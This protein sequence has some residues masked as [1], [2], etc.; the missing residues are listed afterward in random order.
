MIY[1][2]FDNRPFANKNQQYAG[3]F[4]ILFFTPFVIAAVYAHFFTKTEKIE[5]DEDT[6]ISTFLRNF[7]GCP[8][9]RSFHLLI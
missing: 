4:G 7:S 3:L 8:R 9:A 1:L 5:T 6:D 2:Y